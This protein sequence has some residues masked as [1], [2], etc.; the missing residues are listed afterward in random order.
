MATGYLEARPQLVLQPQ[1]NIQ[2]DFSVYLH[3]HAC[4]KV[5]HVLHTYLQETGAVAMQDHSK[6]V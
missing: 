4:G 5:A 1:C 6:M 2:L 3:M